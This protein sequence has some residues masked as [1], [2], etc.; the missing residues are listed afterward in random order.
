MYTPKAFKDLIFLK[1]VSLLDFFS[2]IRVENR[3]DSNN[4]RLLQQ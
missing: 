2:K 3:W 4:P 1:N